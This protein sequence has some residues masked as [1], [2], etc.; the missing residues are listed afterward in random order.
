METKPPARLRTLRITWSVVWGVGTIL[1][2]V[3]WLRSYEKTEVLERTSENEIGTDIVS[4]S[5][6]LSFSREDLRRFE[7]FL[8]P[9]PHGW[10]YQEYERSFERKVSR[11]A[12]AWNDAK[13]E[14]RV[15][16]WYP[17][18]FFTIAA[19]LPWISWKFSL[20][21]LLAATT[22]VAVVL[23]AVVYSMR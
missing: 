3:L 19:V 16:Y 17:F 4:E 8:P 10:R 23:G 20:R 7:S 14:V 9:E 15:P 18:V 22:L 12:F 5:G 11:F 6:T 13:M 2:F 21:T 1:L